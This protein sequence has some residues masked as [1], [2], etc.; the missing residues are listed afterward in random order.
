MAV[1]K[2][3]TSHARKGKRRSHHHVKPRQYAYCGQC[4]EAVLN[5][6]VCNHCGY[7]NSQKREL[8]SVEKTK[9]E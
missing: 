4:G 1:P 5:H 2:R 8:V 3:R 7:S 9:E 6:R